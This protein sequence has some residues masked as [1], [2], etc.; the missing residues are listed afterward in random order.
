M[1]VSIVSVSRRAAPPH[2]GQVG[3]VELGVVGQRLALGD[4]DVHRQ[5][6]GQLV[7][8]HRNE[9]AHRAVDRRDRVA[10]VALT[11]DEPVA[12]AEVDGRLA[13]STLGEPL[14]DRAA[15]PREPLPPGRPVNSPDC[16]MTP[17]PSYASSQSTSVTRRSS[18]PASSA[19]RGSSS[20][21][22]TGGIGRS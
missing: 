13:Q 21:S 5:H 3:L 15:C 8:G 9:S 12:Q 6:D 18:I 22:T 14:G 7:L 4:V 2:F 17:G 1:N 11:G 16:T 20:A 19:S 10:P